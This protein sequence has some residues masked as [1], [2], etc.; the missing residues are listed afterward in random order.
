MKSEKEIKTSN[1]SSDKKFKPQNQAITFDYKLRKTSP[2][3][4]AL[5]TGISRTLR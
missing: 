3:G 2:S 5:V 1:Y 4:W